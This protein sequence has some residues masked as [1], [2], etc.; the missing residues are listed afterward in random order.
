MDSY[1]NNYAINPNGFTN[2]GSI[3]YFNSLIQSILSCTTIIKHAKNNS[4]EYT[5]PLQKEFVNM[6]NNPQPYSTTIMLQELL[7]VLPKGVDIGFH[8]CSSSEAFVYLVDNIPQI[9]KFFD[10]VQKASTECKIC[11]DR[12]SMIL[13]KEITLPI[14]FITEAEFNEGIKSHV[15]NIPEYTCDKCKNKLTDTIRR[16]VL[17]KISEI[18]VLQYT[19]VYN[20]IDKFVPGELLLLSEDKRSSYVYKLVALCEHSGG[21]SG[22]H[23]WSTCLRKNSKLY[24]LNDSSISGC[25]DSSPL[26]ANVYL[27][28]YHFFRME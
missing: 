17:I 1:D 19:S 15:S 4:H 25:S 2:T 6:C 23:Y 11:G 24:T 8:Q 9:R 14:P 16:Y 28:F 18:I 27:A 10:L 7:K 21:L 20:K 12:S 3:C 26:S 5:T 22:G 13:P